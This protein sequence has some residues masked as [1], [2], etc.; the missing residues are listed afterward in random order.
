MVRWSFERAGFCLNPDHLMNPLTVGPT[1]VFGRLDVPEL[2]SDEILV[3][4]EQLDPRQLQRSRQRRRQGIPEPM[5]FAISL[6]LML[7]QQL[8]NVLSAARKRMKNPRMRRNKAISKICRL[9]EMLLSF[10]RGKR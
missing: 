9:C 1:P 5:E 4:S 10:F 6:V 3:Y 7:M 2:S 8:G